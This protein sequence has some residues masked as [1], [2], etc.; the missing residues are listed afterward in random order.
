MKFVSRK[1]CANRIRFDPFMNDETK[2]IETRVVMEGNRNFTWNNWRPEDMALYTYVATCINLPA[3]ITTNCIMDTEDKGFV[4]E[5]L[6]WESSYGID[7]EG[8]EG[9]VFTIKSEIGSVVK[10]I[11]NNTNGELTKCVRDLYTNSY[12]T[13]SVSDIG[14]GAKAGLLG[15][16][17]HY[18]I[19]WDKV[20]KPLPTDLYQMM[21]TIEEWFPKTNDELLDFIREIDHEEFEAAKIKSLNNEPL[22]NIVN[23]AIEEALKVVKEVTEVEEKVEEQIMKHIGTVVN[24]QDELELNHD[25]KL[26]DIEYNK[27]F[28]PH[29]KTQ[30]LYESNINLLLNLSDETGKREASIWYSELLVADLEENSFDEDTIFIAIGK[31]LYVFNLVEKTAWFRRLDQEVEGYE[32]FD[33]VNDLIFNSLNI[34]LFRVINSTDYKL[35]SKALIRE[36]IILIVACTNKDI[37]SKVLFIK[38]LISEVNRL[39]GY[40]AENVLAF[41][42]K[43]R[44]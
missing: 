39:L 13:G 41:I 32:Q 9:F 38:D 24:P 35:D 1:G 18:I 27:Y 3:I 10:Y 44:L 43:N 34:I 14:V 40:N 23:N 17:F 16:F 31:I 19:G 33:A 22:E 15:D 2:Q 11:F 36:L 8:Q 6:Y 25:F 20:E 29:K 12:L 5:W 42:D 4:L 30:D 7:G 28:V 26:E 37:A 21:E